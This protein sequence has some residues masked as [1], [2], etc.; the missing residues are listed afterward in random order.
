MYQIFSLNE[1]G[2]EVLLKENSVEFDVNFRPT[3]RNNFDPIT[4]AAF[5]EEV[6]EYLDDSTLLLST[7]DGTFKTGGSGAAFEGD[8]FCGDQLYHG[9]GTIE[10]NLRAYEAHVRAEQGTA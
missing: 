3:L 1:A 2:E 7:E 8:S 10:E 5:L 6:H 9:G 4:I